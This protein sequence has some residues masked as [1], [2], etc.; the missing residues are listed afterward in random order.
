M[1]EKKQ[2]R[3]NNTYQ[4]N[5]ILDVYKLIGTGYENVWY[6]NCHCRYRCFKGARNSK[7]SYDFIGIEP[8]FKLLENPLRNIIFIRQFQSTQKT[9]TFN[10]ILSMI[11]KLGIYKLFKINKSDLTIT[12]IHTGQVII[13]R[14]F[15]NPFKITSI[16]PAIGYFTD[17]YIE[18]AFEIKSY[19]EFR[20]LD[21]SL[22][23]ALPKGLFFQ[24][25]FLFNA[26][27]ETHWLNEVF[28]KGRLN[29]NFEQLDDPNTTHMEWIDENYML[30]GGYGFGLALHISTF[31]INEFRDKKVYDV[32]MAELRKTAIDIYKVEALGMWGGVN[33]QTYP[34]FNED[35]IQEPPIQSLRYVAIGI[36][37]G[38]S[39]GSGKIIYDKNM[40]LK[41][42]TTMQLVGLTYDNSSLYAVDEYFFSN[43]GKVA[44]KTAPQILQE[45]IETLAEW[46]NHKY[47]FILQ[48]TVCVYVDCADLASRQELELLARENGLYNLRFMP[49]T[50]I[51][52]QTRVDFINLIMAFGEC[53]FSKNCPNLIREIKN[54]QVGEN[55]EPREDFDDHAINSWEYAWQP[56]IR[57][58]RRWGSFKQR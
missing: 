33:G 18:E 36:D 52:I 6:T 45:I 51:S 13:F 48:D 34:H 21:A 12:L 44:P 35:L 9:S 50:K 32:A 37:T 49:S 14:G 23:G 1:G 57:Y 30:P 53:K 2:S 5:V 8:I 10:T 16:Q 4:K 41:S 27:K 54:S 46:V 17:V 19:E 43:Q 38:Y 24:F 15:D 40:R 3:W 39:N 55:G 25:T 28:F 31:R 22:R 20:V 47:R 26:W 11:N 58:L 29:D 42:A 56:I 7:K